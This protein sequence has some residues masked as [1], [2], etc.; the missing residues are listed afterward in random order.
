[1]SDVRPVETVDEEGFV[2]PA[3]CKIEALLGSIAWGTILES[4]D[5]VEGACE[6]KVVIGEWA[7]E[8]VVVL[9][10][11]IDVGWG[12]KEIFVFIGWWPCNSFFDQHSK[13]EQTI[14]SIVFLIINNILNFSM[15]PIIK[16]TN[17]II[18]FL[19]YPSTNHTIL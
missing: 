5:E 11:A 17:F 18:C 8:G 7:L 9:D 1:M 4:V 13:L 3:L 10:G 2:V 16:M 6:P 12:V 15:Q 19:M 14:N